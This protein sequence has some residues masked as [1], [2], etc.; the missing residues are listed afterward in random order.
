MTDALSRLTEKYLEALEAYLA[1]GDE[2]ALSHAYEL[3]RGAMIEGLGVL[4]MAVMHRSAL[5]ELVMT[6]SSD[7]RARY[8]NAAADFLHEA[9]SPFEMSFR[10]YRAANDELR[11]LNERLERQVAATE[12]ANRELEAFS[13]SVSHDLRAPLRSI[14]GYSRILLEDYGEL[15]D[16][17]AKRY[18]Q[19][20][21]DST[22]TMSELIEGLL[23]LAKVSRAEIQRVDV[24]ASH[25][26]RRIAERLA[27]SSPERSCTFTIEPDVTLRGDSRLLTAL[28]ENLIGNA[29]KFTSKRAHAEITFGQEMRDG[30]RTYF[31][32]DNGAG[33]NMDYANKLFG[34]F[35]RL[36]STSEFEGTGIGLAT[37]Q[38]IVN[39]HGGRIWADGKVDG[40]ATFYFTLGGDAP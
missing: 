27:A 36:H 11:A 12:A 7:E 8:A 26:V 40:G 18:L 2:T 39:R 29:W 25:L 23:T 24:N 22:M 30:A 4:D 33:F 32:R 6:A 10:G 17:T 16:D 9:L 28:F 14:D 38:R 5:K 13:Y 15:L 20:V 1:A 19:K 31:V 35:Q 34:A 3:G 37:V 21:H